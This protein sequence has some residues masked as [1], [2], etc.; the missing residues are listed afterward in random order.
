MTEQRHLEKTLTAG[1]PYQRHRHLLSFL[2]A[3]SIAFIERPEVI[4][5]ILARLG[6]WPVSAPVRHPRCRPLG[7]WSR[8]VIRKSIQSMAGENTPSR[9]DVAGVHPAAGPGHPSFLLT[10]G[11]DPPDTPVRRDGRAFGALRVRGRPDSGI[12]GAE[13]IQ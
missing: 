5:K 10:A 4:E 2:P 6:L 12:G 1:L 13:E 7:N 9:P 3:T 11:V 8:R